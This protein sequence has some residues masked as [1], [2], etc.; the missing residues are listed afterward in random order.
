MN[1]IE[2]IGTYITYIIVITNKFENVKDPT[3]VNGS[4]MKQQILP[5]VTKKITLH[6]IYIYIYTGSCMDLRSS[7]QTRFASSCRH[8]VDL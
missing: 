8:I 5:T 6:K 4:K 2:Y 3:N 7:P 1:I